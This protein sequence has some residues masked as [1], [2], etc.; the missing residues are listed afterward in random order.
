MHQ[1][2]PPKEHCIRNINDASLKER[3]GRR[4]NQIFIMKNAFF[5]LTSESLKRMQVTLR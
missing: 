4:K 3:T 2:E 1:I 5:H